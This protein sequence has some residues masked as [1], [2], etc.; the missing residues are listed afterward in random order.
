MRGVRE[1]PL[2]RGNQRFDLTCGGIESPGKLRHLVAPAHRNAHL[3]IALAER[4]NTLLQPFEVLRQP[5]D[6]GI[7]GGSDRKADGEYQAKPA[8]GNQ[9]SDTGPAT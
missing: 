1:Q 6:K 8:Q 3:Q 7:G 5:A 2:L 9:E 4:R